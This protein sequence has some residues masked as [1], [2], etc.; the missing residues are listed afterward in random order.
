MTASQYHHMFNYDEDPAH[1][2]MHPEIAEA[3]YTRGTFTYRPDLV[4]LIEAFLENMS[5]ELWPYVVCFRT[6]CRGEFVVKFQITGNAGYP[7]F[8]EL[9][10]DHGYSE[11]TTDSRDWTFEAPIVPSLEMVTN[12]ANKY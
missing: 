7:R 9:L 11:L 10:I 6:G 1:I 4:P 3:S 12:A 8:V 2:A 5:A